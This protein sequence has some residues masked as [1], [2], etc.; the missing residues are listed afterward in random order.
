MKHTSRTRRPKK[1]RYAGDLFNYPG[2]FS[3]LE[4]L[5]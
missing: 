3:L 5:T 2:S 1:L 4:A